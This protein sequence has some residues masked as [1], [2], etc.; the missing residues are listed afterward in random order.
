MS[1]RSLVLALALLGSLV[2]DA[3]VAAAP[4]GDRA[5][6]VSVRYSGPVQPPLPVRVRASAWCGD[7]ET[8]TNRADTEL[9][10]TKL[11]HV[12]YAV[13]SDGPDRFATY[14]PAI[15]TDL[16][17]LDA[18]WRAQD[19]SRTLRLDLASFPCDSTIGRLDLSFVR[20][21][22]ASSAYLGNG[23]PRLEHLINA[24]T[25]LMPQN[26]KTLVYYDGPVSSDA[27][28][29][30]GTTTGISPTLGGPV[31]LSVDWMQSSCPRDFGQGGFQSA[32][33][34]HELLHNLGAQP[35]T[36]PCSGDPYH[37][38]DSRSDVLYPVASVSST[39][40]NVV[41]DFGHDDY[42]AHSGSWFDVQDSEWLEHLPQ[43][44][45]S[46]GENGSGSV[47]LTA[48]GGALTC[49]PTCA[50]TLDSDTAVKLDAQPAAGSR[51]VRWE[52][53]CTGA[54]P[55][56]AVTMS[57][58]KNATAVFGPASYSVRVAVAGKGKVVST[59]AGVS[60]PSRCRATFT[61]PVTLRARPSA[62]YRFAGWS[63]ACSGRGVCQ[64][65]I[66]HAGAVRATF[67]KR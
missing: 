38:C 12:V 17:A 23:V 57:G 56:C 40:A 22:E 64:L 66:D 41:L 43:V 36:H 42:Y 9:S 32:T 21:P 29:T 34:A 30:C 46:V 3:A 54:A 18:W 20:L 45:L 15:V 65:S 4:A 47:L 61:A 53:D 27:R 6:G 59:P 7:G 16:T 31:A 8:S 49:A 67:R 11:I 62:K 60:C 1:S 24:L 33:A 19:P 10:S 48:P 44:A 39:L 25:S 2:A 37:P 5:A 51:F 63:G 52:G 13:P 50:A 55:S 26:V 35:K 58:A 28:F 14:A